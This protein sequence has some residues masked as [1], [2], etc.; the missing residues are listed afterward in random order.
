LLS[1][2]V[3]PCRSIRSSLRSALVVRS[4]VDAALV[5]RTV[6]GIP[7]SM[8]MAFRISGSSIVSRAAYSFTR[9]PPMTR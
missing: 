4:S 5:I 7:V 6:A 1:T 8:P 9:D 2:V 3:I